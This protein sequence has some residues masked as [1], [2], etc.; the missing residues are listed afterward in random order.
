MTASAVTPQSAPFAQ[1]QTFSATITNAGAAYAGDSTT[2]F[3]RATDAGGSGA[4]EVGTAAT[5]ALN[6]GTSRN[7][8]FSHTFTTSGNFYLR[9]CADVS[10]TVTESNESNNCGP[11][12]HVV[13]A[14]PP[15]SVDLTA[16]PE[17][18]TA[19]ASSLLNWASSNADVCSSTQF[20]TFGAT[21]GQVSV[22][23]G[24]TTLYSIICKKNGT[25]STGTYRYSFS[26]TSDLACPITDPNRVY[27][28]LPT[29]PANPSGKS[30]TGPCKINRVG[31][32]PGGCAIYT[33]VYECNYSAGTPSQEAEDSVTVTVTTP[34]MP[35]LTA[36]S[37]TPTTAIAGTS[38]TF[39]ATVSNIG[40]SVARASA[41]RF[42]RATSAEGAGATT[43]ND[44]TTPAITA[45][46]SI[47]RSASY[48]FTSAGTYYVRACADT[49]TAV[50]E[51][52]EGNNCGAWT[53]ITVTTAES[54][55]VSC[56]VS[57][58]SVPPGGSVTYNA[59]PAGGASAPFT[60]TASDGASVG[61]GATVTRTFSTPGT[62]AMNVRASGTSVSYCPNVSVTA[63]WCTAGTPDL[64][65]TATPT[66]VRAGQQVTLA[67]SASGVNGQNATCTVS[68]P[69]VSWS[70]AVSASPQC[71][72]SG[73]ANPS[74]NTQSTYTLTCAGVSESTTVNVIPSFQEF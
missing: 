58:T 13:V 59:N 34:T 63:N 22:S 73:S 44:V 20:D 2:R 54:P 65:I 8:S 45:G 36:G 17:S 3:Q 61:T 48:T 1:A 33:D 4:Y 51:S 40:A 18:I 31:E 67:W 52:N 9:A 11:W 74:I 49:A 57:A 69:G 60:W 43:I 14:S 42:Q 35:D 64:T 10:G 68:G 39:S 47:V 55:T 21:S 37:I 66:R 62:Y 7:V 30:C 19:G 28:G 6:P 27:Y 38:Q 26:D 23:P 12:T 46:G 50:S 56:S 29:C 72:A 32:Y 70:S 71:S 53:A 5:G 24:E 16:V 25:G 41:T 15:P